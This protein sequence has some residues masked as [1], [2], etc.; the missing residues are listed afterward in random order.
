MPISPPDLKWYKS[1]T[2]ADTSA[3]GGRMSAAQ[4]PSGV[5]NNVLP[6]VTLSERTTGVTR[7]RKL[8]IKVENADSIPLQNA[9]VFVQQA[10]PGQDSVCFFPGTQR[11]TQ[12]SLTGSERLYGAGKL[13]AT[14]SAGA[15]TILVA[16]EGAALSYL[17]AGDLL[18]ITDKAT[19]AAP[20]SEE[21]VVA[22]SVTY[23]GDVANVTL[24]T[25][26]ASSYAA[27]AATVSSVYQAG[28]VKARAT[29]V[30]VS[31]AAGLFDQSALPLDS[32]G[33]VEQSWTLTFTSATAFTV[34][35]DTLGNIGSGN[36]AS[37]AAPAHPSFPGKAYFTVPGTAFGGAFAA[38][39]TVTFTTSPAAIPVWYRQSVPAGAAAVSGNQV[40]LAVDGESA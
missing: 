15:K 24:A 22:Q 31:S 35:G 9:R 34:T 38:G 36:I 39:D 4:S 16:T 27:N 5:K 20:G 10:T 11:D 3:N 32:T 13:S 17:R 26:L 1:L 2:I 8:F 30:Q 18:R 12:A 19:V 37:G 21:F 6:D 25:P 14:A 7:H 29:E 28:E 40:I 33:T 23:A